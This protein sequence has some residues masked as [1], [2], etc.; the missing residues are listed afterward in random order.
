MTARMIAIE[1]AARHWYF[2]PR[3][4][5]AILAGASADEYSVEC[6][7][8]QLDTGFLARREEERIERADARCVLE[9]AAVFGDLRFGMPE[10]EVKQSRRSLDPRV[11]SHRDDRMNTKHA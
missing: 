6:A 8:A 5:R 1:Q 4:R 7:Q 11:F 3:S 10:V 2:A 9:I